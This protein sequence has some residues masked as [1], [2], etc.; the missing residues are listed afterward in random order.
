M[1]IE[2]VKVEKNVTLGEL[3]AIVGFPSD[4]EQSDDSGDSCVPNDLEIEILGDAG[5]HKIEGFRWTKQEQLIELYHC[6]FSM[7]GDI[8]IGSLKCSPE[9]IVKRSDG[10][11]VYAKDLSAV[12]CIMT[13][14]GPKKVI[15]VVRCN[16]HERLCDLQVADVHSYY[17]NG[18]LSHNSHLLTMLGA[19]AL[20]A[21][22]NVLHYTFELSE[23][24]TGIRYDSNLCDID[25]NDVFDNKDAIRA[26]YAEMKDSLGRLVI[27]FYPSGSAT[28]QTIRAH[29][30]KLELK[31]F[32]P[33]ILLI[34]Y[35]DIM[36]S[37]RQYDS[38]RHE[39]KLIYT[40]LRGLA[41]ELQLP[42]W[43]ACFHGD[44]EIASPSGKFKIK[45]RVGQSGFLVYSYNHELKRLELKTV[46]SVYKSGENVEV[47]KVTLDNGREVVVTPNHKFMLRDGT[48]RE[49]RELQVG[50]S[51]MPYY[52][53]INPQD[54]RK[55]IYK[56]DG[57]WEYQ[58][59]MVADWKFGVDRPRLHQVHHI[60]YDKHNDDPDNLQL[61]TISEHYKVHSRVLWD[62][63]VPC[64]LDYLRERY[65][66]RMKE[67]NPMFDPVVRAKMSASR[68]G[69]CMGDDNPMRLEENK[70]KKVSRRIK[71]SLKF[72]EYKATAA[73]KAQA[74]WARKTD[75]ERK[76]IG[77]KVKEKRE[78]T[79]GY[80]PREV[81]IQRLQEIAMSSHSLKEYI[82]KAK[83][84]PL[85]GSDKLSIWR[86]KN[87]KIAKIEPAGFADV[88]NMEVDDNH[89]YALDAGIVV[90]NS[91]SNREGA[92]ADVVDITNM[93]ESYGKAAVADA[94]ITLSRKSYEKAS[95]WGR[96]FIAKNRAGVDGIIF[97]VK[98][99]TARSTFT[100]S[101]PEDAVQNAEQGQQDEV[102]KRLIEK[103]NELRRD[104]ITK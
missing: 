52:E 39:L 92:T 87:H 66:Q 14:T 10:T 28:V 49:L 73:A 94:I 88:Y 98:I 18:I 31:G 61:L 50:D 70:K 48:Y 34:D 32:K 55:M 33:D 53:K 103:M 1:K 75:E 69:K 59:K 102:K 78:Q 62:P 60:D 89:N 11:W 95:G 5:Y 80:E 65:S 54:H 44:T 24:K 93:A 27:K 84:I 81:R 86:H 85:R 30:E 57:S 43:S 58:Y 101:P 68:K 9:H 2:R 4:A 22:K 25:S 45:D 47:W 90:K 19:N 79:Y 46:K 29:M 56:N 51:L 16:E 76:A 97:P 64:S 77:R 3:F 15:G 96:L 6:G 82:E 99:N 40:E 37:S 83:A 36:K 13:Q 7:D 91:Q 71:E 74:A 21:R 8:V 26:R 104:K 23:A 72:L 20:R 100:L 12:D 17:A 38:L 35:A 67:Y 63:H 42:I 41:D